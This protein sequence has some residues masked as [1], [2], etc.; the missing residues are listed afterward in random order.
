MVEKF[1]QLATALANQAKDNDIAIHVARDFGQQ[2]GL[3]APGTGKQ[4]GP[5][6]LTQGQ[7]PVDSPY[8]GWQGARNARPLRGQGRIAYDCT[9][10]LARRP[11]KSARAALD[12]RPTKAVEHLP[13]QVIADANLMHGRQGFNC[14]PCAYTFK[15]RQRTERGVLLITADDLRQ[16]PCVARRLNPAQIPYAGLGQTTVQQ[17]AIDPQDPTVPG[18]RTK[19]RQMRKLA[20]LPAFKTL[21]NGAAHQFTSWRC[22][23][24]NSTR[25][26]SIAVRRNP[27]TSS[28]KNRRRPSA[29]TTWAFGPPMIWTILKGSTVLVC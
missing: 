2:G 4:P 14:R 15:A 20:L 27:C 25:R 5:L 23:P 19:A 1:T 9:R 6:P 21:C 18:H 8:P 29:N 26:L 10:A 17:Q 22:L 12:K 13:Q 28:P 24:S 3:A 11:G 16:Y 7:Q